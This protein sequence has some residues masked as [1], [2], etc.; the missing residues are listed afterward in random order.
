MNVVFGKQDV[1]ELAINIVIVLRVSAF[2]ACP[3]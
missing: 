1:L 3:Q 2:T